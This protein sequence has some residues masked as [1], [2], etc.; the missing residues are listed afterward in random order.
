MSV[1]TTTHVNFRG[2]AREAL[3]FYKSVFGGET[4][5]ATYA[6]IHAVEE[7]IQAD[8]VA[9]GRLSAPIGFTIMAYDVQPSKGYDPGENAFYVSLQGTAG[10]EIQPLWDAPR[11]LG[12]HH[13]HSARPSP[14]RSPLQN[15]HRP[16]RR[17]LDRRRRHHPANRLTEPHL[18]MM[19]RAP[20]SSSSNASVSRSFRSGTVLIPKGASI[21]S[22]AEACGDVFELAGRARNLALRVPRGLCAR[23]H[24]INIFGAATRSRSPRRPARVAAGS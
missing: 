21:T 2:R 13:P 3:E 23:A 1:T 20:D 19:G 22:R 24:D 6:N 15:A 16:R 10:D 18:G 9:F 5:I 12:N 8:Q 7:P 14:L 17:H 11:R 4:S